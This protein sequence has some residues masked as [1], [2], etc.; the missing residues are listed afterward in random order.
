MP[1]SDMPPHPAPTHLTPEANRVIW[2]L[3]FSAFVVILNETT[4][5]I[6][7]RP[8]MTDLKISAIT[9]QWLTT[10]F[11]L[12][13]AV[14]IPI[15]G[16]LLQRFNTRTV[17]LA[18]MSLFTLGT[19][20]A[21]LAPGF[22]TLLIGRVVQASGTAIMM[23]LLMTTIMTLVPASHRGLMI[24]NVSLVMSVAPAI[25]PTLSGFLL[26]FSGWRGIFVTMLPIA[27][28]ML[29]IGY[30]LVRNVGEPTPL[31]LDATSVVLSAIGFGGSVYGLSQIASGGPVLPPLL[32]GIVALALFVWRQ[33]ALQRD[34]SPLLDLRTLRHAPFAISLAMMVVLMASMFG[35]LI[36][37]PIYLQ[38][39]LGFTPLVAGLILLPGGVAMG[40][41]ARPIGAAYDSVG[42]RP[43][44]IPGTIGACAVL[45]GF[46]LL[47]VD[48]PAWA[49]VVGYSILC[50]SLAAVFTPLFTVGLGSVEPH[51]YSYASALLGS[52]Q[53]V[54][55][56]AG[57]ALFVTIYTLTTASSSDPADLASG[58]RAAML[59]GA[60]L[61]ILPIIGSMLLR[62]PEASSP[63]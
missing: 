1:S 34:G 60:V 10:A 51:Q 4:M 27:C 58:V 56:A 7:L 63:S 22:V 39:V 50:V 57:T 62:K 55:G 16:W 41:L 31:P 47:G 52:L 30:A 35:A 38:A 32:I 17:Y 48:T 6:A 23:P 40:L 37:L 54:A 15:T 11:M 36:V 14:V 2:L 42:P 8:V 43:L 25:G 28:I 24:G 20:V 12:T 19:L 49:V 18:S 44:V 61:A 53:Q 9:G 26:G 33:L 13:M 5:G 29:V 21:A 45:W 46:T 59:V 3:V